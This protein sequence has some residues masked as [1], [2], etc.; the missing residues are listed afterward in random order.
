MDQNAVVYVK[1]FLLT[2]EVLLSCD[3]VEFLWQEE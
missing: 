1:V 3:A 2:N